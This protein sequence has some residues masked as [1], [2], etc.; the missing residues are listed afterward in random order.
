MFNKSHQERRCEMQVNPNPV[1]I[2][3]IDLYE[4]PIKTDNVILKILNC[5]PCIGGFVGLFTTVSLLNDRQAAL[6]AGDKTRLIKIIHVQNQYLKGTIGRSVVE[7][8]LAIACLTSCIFL[9]RVTSPLHVI[10]SVVVI[11]ASI[12]MISANARL[13]AR[14]IKELRELQTSN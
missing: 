8:A 13:L 1:Y 4:E 10:S 2:Q 11:F 14:N 6:D 5:I 9:S 3:N 12:Y 7:L